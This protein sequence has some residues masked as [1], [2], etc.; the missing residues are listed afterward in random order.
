[1]VSIETMPMRGTGVSPDEG[2]GAVAQA[3]REAV[4]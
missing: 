2:G 3:A 1:M 4:A